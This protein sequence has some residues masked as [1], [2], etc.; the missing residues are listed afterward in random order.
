MLFR[1]LYGIAFLVTILGITSQL[2]RSPLSG[3]VLFVVA[4]GLV[5]ERAVLWRLRTAARYRNHSPVREPIE[6]R[7]EENNL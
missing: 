7:I 2:S 1:N 6:L 5:L 3:N 4:A